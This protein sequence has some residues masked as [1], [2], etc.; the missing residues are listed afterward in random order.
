[1]DLNDDLFDLLANPERSIAK[2]GNKTS[3]ITIDDE[4]IR[5]LNIKL[6]EINVKTV[7]DKKKFEKL[8]EYI[9]ILK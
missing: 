3:E 1:M 7:I 9:K 8:I 6:S 4:I 2:S 5:L